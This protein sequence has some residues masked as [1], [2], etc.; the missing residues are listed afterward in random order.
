MKLVRTL[1]LCG[2]LIVLAARAVLPSAPPM[3]EGFSTPNQP[4]NYCSPPSNLAGSNQ[5]P[6]S[7]GGVLQASGNTNQ[8]GSH[9]TPDNQLL[10]FFPKGAVTAPGAT[11]YKVS[12]KANCQPPA[13]PGKNRVVGNAYD[14]IVLG[15]PGDLAVNFLQQAQVLMR[16]PPV[17]YTSVQIYYD[18]QWH[19]TQWGQQADIANIT[20]EHSGTISALDDGSSNP[21]G[22]PPSQQ[23]PIVTI[24]E[25]ILLSAAI[26]IVVAAIIVQRRRSP[27]ADAP[28]H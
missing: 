11:S 16:T 9:S 6:T 25:I 21:A 23:T 22:K 1:G 24:V 14:V 5:Q 2:I 7:G 12:L 19:S 13:P 4:Y 10:T 18:G 15:E 27:G 20:I 3:Y 17:R 28:K 26:G 8:L